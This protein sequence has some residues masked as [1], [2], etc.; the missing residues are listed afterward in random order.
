MIFE[1]A[2][3]G[4]ELILLG[5]I[6]LAMGVIYTYLRWR[7][8]LD[9]LRHVWVP[10]LL[11]TITGTLDALVTIVGTWGDPWAEGNPF[12]RQMLI[13]DGWIGQ[14]L[15]TFL[16]IL[17]WAALVVGLEALRRRVGSFSTIRKFAAYL[18]GAVQLLLLYRL[19]L[20]HLEGFLSWTPY[21][22]PIAQVVAFFEDHTPWLFSDSLVGYVLDLGTAFGAV[23]VALHLAVAALL[24]RLGIHMP[25]VRRA[26]TNLRQAHAAQPGRATAR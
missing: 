6:G 23:C 19:G 25:M 7:G 26:L 4:Q 14:L 9:M 2:L 18:L 5:T 21:Y 20:W 22:Q 1:R 13:W 16:W 10:S 17:F 11:W 12:L 24:P 3:L 8:Q 15:Y